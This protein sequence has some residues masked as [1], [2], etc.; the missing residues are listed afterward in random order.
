MSSSELQFLGYFHVDG[1]L[2][3]ALK[4][5]FYTSICFSTETNFEEMLEQ[6]SNLQKQVRVGKN[7]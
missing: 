6:T 7:V 4:N 5:F 3:S 1:E 2:Y